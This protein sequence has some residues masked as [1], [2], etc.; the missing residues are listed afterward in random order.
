MKSLNAKKIIKKSQVSQ[1]D[2][3]I[4]IFLFY[5]IFDSRIKDLDCILEN[6]ATK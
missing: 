4:Q 6:L 5:T 1:Y 3:L 2:L